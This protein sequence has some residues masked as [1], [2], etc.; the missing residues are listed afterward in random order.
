MYYENIL[1]EK[2]NFATPRNTCVKLKQV[3]TLTNTIAHLKY[4]FKKEGKMA[5]NKLEILEESGGFV[6]FCYD[7]TVIGKFS[8]GEIIKTS[9]K[10]DFRS[11]GNIKLLKEGE[12]FLQIDLTNSQMP[13]SRESDRVIFYVLNQKNMLKYYA[14]I[15]ELIARAQYTIDP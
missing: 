8:D 9:I 4:Y 10:A 11:G 3:Y 5:F 12:V 1:P 7:A 14:L 15:N 6:D 13:P 2:N